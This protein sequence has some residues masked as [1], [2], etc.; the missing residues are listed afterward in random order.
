MELFEGL[1]AAHFSP[2]NHDGSLNLPIIQQYTDRLVADG[3]AGIFVNGSNGEGPNLTIEERMQVAEAFI[4]AAAGRIKLFIHV[5]HASIRESRKLAAHAEEIG[6]DAISAVASFYF[7]PA[8]V[9]TLV[10]CMAQIASAA[11]NTP[12]YYYHIPAIT[13]VGMDMNVF[14]A[15][16]QSKIPTLKGIKYTAPTLHEYQSCIT[17]TNGN[18]DLLYGTDEML[19]S[20]LA[21]G[22]KGAIGS[23]YNFAAPL[24]L[25]VMQAYNSGETEAARLHQAYLVEVVKAVIKYPPIPAQKAVMKMLG[26]DLGP[27][28]LPLPQLSAQDYDALQTELNTLGFF[29]KLEEARASLSPISVKA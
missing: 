24:Y 3:L 13:G 16:G 20:S 9:H 27:C 8:S 7:K 5:G 2:L 23:T 15:E 21:V 28:L 18:M 17:H 19:L 6:A 4:A 25:K 22:A 14:L 26:L 1:M 11:P 10:N 12:F 29:E